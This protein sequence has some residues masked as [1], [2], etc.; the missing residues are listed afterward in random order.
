MSTFTDAIEHNWPD[1]VI[2]PG[3]A[4]SC[5]DCRRDFNV[6][7]DMTDDDEI[8]EYLSQYDEGSFSWR[9]CDSCGSNLG[10]DRHAAHAIHREAFGPDAKQPDNVHHIDICT[11]C[12]LFHANGDEPEE[13]QAA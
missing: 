7:D 8:Q 13:W 11:D 12:L 10:G 6:P 3:V 9:Q 2:A 5:G 4:S 1:Y